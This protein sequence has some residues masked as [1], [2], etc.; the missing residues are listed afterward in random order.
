MIKVLKRKFGGNYKS[1][2]VSYQ[3]DEVFIKNDIKNFN[4]IFLYKK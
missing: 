1:R 3:L 2:A 4:E